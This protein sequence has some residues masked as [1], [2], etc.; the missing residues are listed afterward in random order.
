MERWVF[1]RSFQPKS[2]A[3]PVVNRN[4]LPFPSSL[5]Q[6]LNT[7]THQRHSHVHATTSQNGKP[8]QCHSVRLQLVCESAIPSLL[9]MQELQ[10]ASPMKYESYATPDYNRPQ[11]CCNPPIYR[12]CANINRISPPPSA[13]SALSPPSW[14][15]SWSSASRPR[16]R[17]PAASS[18]PSP[19]SR[20]LTRA[21]SS[22][23]A[24]VLSTRMASVCPW[25]FLPVT[26]S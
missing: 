23:S 26:G 4:T 12:S 16:P 17:P 3:I 13:P 9:S 5:C 2:I 21:R 14:T 18:S 6:F 7:S 25:V 20:S 11:H 24:P 15:A 22:P 19:V 10:I 8:A 1:S